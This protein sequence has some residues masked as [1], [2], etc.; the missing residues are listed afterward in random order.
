MVRGRRGG[1]GTPRLLSAAHCGD[2]AS[3]QHEDP[4]FHSIAR[5][6]VHNGA[7]LDDHGR[8]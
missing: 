8:G 6:G 4:V 1:N 5:L 2:L 3:F 7:A